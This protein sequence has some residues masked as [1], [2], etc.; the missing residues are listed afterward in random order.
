MLMPWIQIRNTAY[1][2]VLRSYEK[3]GINKP[4]APFQAASALCLNRMD[5]QHSMSTNASRIV[6]RQ[7]LGSSEDVQ[8]EFQPAS[9]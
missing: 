8:D 6:H 1:N 7:E 5:N 3:Q 2:I 9:K 4:V